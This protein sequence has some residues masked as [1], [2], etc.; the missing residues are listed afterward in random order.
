M[1]GLLVVFAIPALPAVVTADPPAPT[2]HPALIPPVSL[3]EGE[4][5]VCYSGCGGEIPE[6]VNVDY[7][8][9]VAYLVNQARD[10]EGLPPLKLVESFCQFS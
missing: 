2:R 4:V 5:S 7:E 9:E 1:V 6:A 8:Q 10:V 3:Q